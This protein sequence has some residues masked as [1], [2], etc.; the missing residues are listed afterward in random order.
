MSRNKRG[1]AH[2]IKVF[3]NEVGYAVS[4]IFWAFRHFKEIKHFSF[5]VNLRKQCEANYLEAQRTENTDKMKK[6][7]IQ[8][9]LLDKILQYGKASQ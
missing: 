4:I 5:L 1:I 2:R 9:N 3:V 8:K 7:E 6:A